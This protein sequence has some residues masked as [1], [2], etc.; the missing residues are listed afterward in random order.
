M[1]PLAYSS[2]TI[3]V[4]IIGMMIGGLVK[5][6]LGAGLPAVGMPIMVL[7][8]EPV[9]A[10]TLFVVPVMISNII[11]IFQ[12]GHYKT[13]VL[14]F[15]PFLIIFIIGVW[16]GAQALTLVDP[17]I[18]AVAIGWVVISTTVGQ[19]WANDIVIS[20]RRGRIIHPLAGGALGLCGG[21]T[22]MF[23]PTI[24][25]FASLSLPK[26]LFVTLLALAAMTGSVT[27]YSR[28]YVEGWIGFTQMTASTMAL[29]PAGLGLI[30]G[31]WLRKHM[32]ERVFRRTVW[33]ALFI[34]GIGL[35]I[36][37]TT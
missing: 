30:A 36:K 10:V 5:G 4:I 20:E 27:M 29:L 12:G 1:D 2:I 25:Y 17:D 19:I 33:S 35:I 13:A 23:T 15:A 11:Q 8:I 31:I 24:V 26:D 18:M 37:G 3:L 34:L 21:A 22:G 6:A 14:Q 7:Q 9:Q 32:S 28:L 16:F